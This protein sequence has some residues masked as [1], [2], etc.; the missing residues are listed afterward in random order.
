LIAVL[1]LAGAVLLVP[2]ATAGNF[3]EARMGCAGENPATCPTGTTGQPYSLRFLLQGDEDL[4]CASFSVSSG[5]LPPGLTVSGH[6]VSG[7]PTQAGTFDFY[8]TVTY[9]PCIKPASDDFFRININEGLPK[10]TIG[11]ESTPPGTTG[12][13]YSLQMTASAPEAK[14]WSIS[15]GALPPGLAIDAN[16]GLISGT[17]TAAGTFNFVVLAKMNGDTRSDTKALGIVI[18][19]PLTITAA[20]P[21]T[22][23][24]RA[25]TE[26]GLPFE[27]MLAPTGGDGTYT[28][29]STGEP[30]PGLS[31]ADGAISGT[32][33]AAGVYNFT[34]TVTDAE[35]RLA[36][37]LARIVVLER[38][39]VTT[40]VLRPGVVGKLFRG[41]LTTTGGAKPLTWRVVAGPLPRGVRLYTKTGFLYGRAKQAGR[42]RVT[43]EATDRLGATATKT[44]R[45]TILAPKK[46][47][48]PKTP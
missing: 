11:P 12:A 39:E 26:V 3:D 47:K 20:D 21:F 41:R 33:T 25:L 23:A 32:P 22:P 2:G 13:A 42:F 34:V 27:A 19:D 46:P 1:A 15:S 43:F 24:R 44:L 29:S 30:P 4:G 7:T 8:M 10:L 36:N 6:T 45:I 48:K 40:L 14:S 31:I 18:R 16:T 28:W 35:G 37:Y 9:A 17:P 5:S 38:L